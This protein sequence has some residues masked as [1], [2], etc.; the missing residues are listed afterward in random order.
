MVHRLEGKGMPMELLILFT[1]TRSPALWILLK[2]LFLFQHI[3]VRQ[4]ELAV[5]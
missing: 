3:H 4:L 2:L 1:P 5:N